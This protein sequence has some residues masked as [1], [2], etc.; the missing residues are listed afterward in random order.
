MIA[1]LIPGEPVAFARSGGTVQ[2]TYG[3]LAG[4]AVSVMVLEQEG[5]C[6]A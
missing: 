3:L 5:G 1:F 2:K 4:V 6:H